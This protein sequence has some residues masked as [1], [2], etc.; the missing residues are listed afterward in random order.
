MCLN[1]PTWSQCGIGWMLSYVWTCWIFVRCDR[2]IPF[3]VVFGYSLGF[4]AV[5]RLF[6]QGLF[7][8]F[9]SWENKLVS[10]EVLV[11]CV[12]SDRQC[13]LSAPLEFQPVCPLSLVKGHL[14]LWDRPVRPDSL[15]ISKKFKTNNW[16]YVCIILNSQL[17]TLGICVC[18]W[19]FLRRWIA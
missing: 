10:I 15:S 19:C 11:K 6:L 7:F 14:S 16:K 3:H 5:W 1:T 17:R 8:F 9:C 13:F 18:V 2:V 4:P 12:Y